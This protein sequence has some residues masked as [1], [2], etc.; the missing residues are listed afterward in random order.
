MTDIIDAIDATLDSLDLCG[1]GCGQKLTEGSASPWYAGEACQAR[2][3]ARGK[4]TSSRLARATVQFSRPVEDPV[5]EALR[6][7]LYACAFEPH[8][9]FC[10]SCSW[11]M[12]GEVQ[13]VMQATRDHIDQVHPEPTAALADAVVRPAAPLADAALDHIDTHGAGRFHAVGRGDN[14]REVPCDCDP[15]AEPWWRRI[16]RSR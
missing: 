15:P 8:T 14:A 6:S 7:T 9:S 16:W 12:T 13:R 11:R 3:M 5:A 2:W 4:E 1:C 10:L